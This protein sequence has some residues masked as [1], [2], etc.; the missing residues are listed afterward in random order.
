MMRAVLV[1]ALELGLL[2]HM[3]RWEARR[4]VIYQQR[5]VTRSI[6]LE[7]KDDIAAAG[8]SAS[9]L[10][11]GID[12]ATYTSHWPV[13]LEAWEFRDG[14]RRPLIRASVYGE[15]GRFALRPITVKTYGSPLDDAW[16]ERLLRAYRANG[17]RY[18]VITQPAP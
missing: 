16:L 1:A 13:R 14:R 2:A 4:V 11:E 8:R 15:N 18:E 10:R 7:A 5:D 17:W 3:Q 6:V 12:R 9:E